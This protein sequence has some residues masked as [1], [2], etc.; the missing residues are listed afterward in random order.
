[1]REL[2]RRMVNMARRMVNTQITSDS[3]DVN[4][5]SVPGRTTVCSRIMSFS[6]RRVKT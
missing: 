2:A 1:M 6:L 5:V 3:P 4:G